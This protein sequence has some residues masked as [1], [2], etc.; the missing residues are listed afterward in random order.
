MAMRISKDRVDLDDKRLQKPALQDYSE[1]VV[2]ET[3]SGANH[4]IDLEQKNVHDITLTAD[5]A[6]TFA[7]PPVSGSAGRLTVFLRQDSTGS[8]TVTWPSAVNWL[9]GEAP[10]LYAYP[11]S[12]NVLAFV[13]I[14]GGTTWFGSE[15]GKINAYEPQYLDYGYFAAG[16]G[17]FNPIYSDVDRLDYSNDTATASQR[18][19]LSAARYNLAATQNSPV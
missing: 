6:L 11:G 5:C 19:P 9:D 18:G 15:A 16:G 17:G 3:D 4:T 14:D 1:V 13:T 12:I 8:R 7:N 10:T 2:T